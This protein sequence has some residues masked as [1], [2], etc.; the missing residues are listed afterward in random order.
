MESKFKKSSKWILAALIPFMAACGN[1]GNQVNSDLAIPVSVS[2][3]VK[4]PIIQY[5]STT[6]TATAASQTTLNT[7]MAGIYFLV[8]N[9]KT[10]SDFKLGDIVEKG[11]VIVRLE[12]PESEN[13]IAI[14]TKKLNLD[15][16]ELEFQ[17]QKSLYEKG[18]V[19]LREMK[20]S[21]VALATANTDFENAKIQLAKFQVISPFKGAIVDLPQVTSGTRVIANAA[22][23]T[24][25]DYSK[26]LMEINLPE[27]NI[28]TINVGQEVNITNYTLPKDTLKA[29]INELS[30][31]VSTET[32]TFK[33]K[34]VID[35]AALKL[36]PGM[37]VKA[38][39]EVARRDSAIVISKDI[40]VSGNRGKAVYIVEKG[41]SRER[42]ITTGL[43]NETS[44]EVIEGLK[45]NERVVT[46]GFETLRNNSKVKIINQ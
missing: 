46:K 31:V 30:P 10:G 18:G 34:L 45:K 20:N 44:V 33:G 7:E 5:I 40:I 38:D 4:K 1:Q 24:L 22:V 16:S 26:L 15:I 8:K 23:V 21:E 25:M 41:A 3:V 6:G 14:K 12:N 37:F 2:D 42:I 28:T 32:R 29:R 43:E 19:T 27:K 35:N 9:P 36:R 17:K 39:I 11:Q 13:S